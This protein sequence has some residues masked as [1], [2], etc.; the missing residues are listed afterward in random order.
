MVFKVS[1]LA[2]EKC[3]FAVLLLRGHFK[4]VFLEVLL[5]RGGI[6]KVFLDLSFCDRICCCY[7]DL[8]ISAVL[9]QN[10]ATAGIFSFHETSSRVMCALNFGS[11]F[12]YTH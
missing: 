12:I 5:L 9:R 10:L 11:G 1:H 8:T 7:Q 2:F 3:F 4:S 6:S